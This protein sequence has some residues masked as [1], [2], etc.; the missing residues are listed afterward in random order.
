MSYNYFH[1]DLDYL[2]WNPVPNAVCDL[3]GEEGICLRPQLSNYYESYKL[4]LSLEELKNL[5]EKNHA[6]DNFFYVSLKAIA[7]GKLK[8]IH[9]IDEDFQDGL[10]DKILDKLSRTPPY[11]GEGPWFM[12]DGD[13]LPFIGIWYSDD[14]EEYF[15]TEEEQQ[16]FIK[17]INGQ[18]QETP[19]TL[20]TMNLEGR[21]IVFQSPKD[22]SLFAVYQYQG[23]G[24]F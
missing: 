4:D 6:S 18:Y 23:P 17:S 21:T 7:Y 16:T 19:L 14:V 15:D 8:V 5:V 2:G 9:Y 22:Q 10:N 12:L 3:T 13:I 11:D 24:S 20:D 1:A